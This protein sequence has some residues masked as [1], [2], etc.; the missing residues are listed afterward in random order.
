MRNCNSFTKRQ[1]N[2][3]K[4]LNMRIAKIN[5]P[6][7]EIITHESYKWTIEQTKQFGKIPKIKFY[8]HSCQV[9]AEIVRESGIIDRNR[10][11][12]LSKIRQKYGIKESR[13]SNARLFEAELNNIMLK[14]K[15]AVY[16]VGYINN[17][18]TAKDSSIAEPLVLLQKIVMEEQAQS[19]GDNKTL[20][21]EKTAD[22]S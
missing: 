4:A 2:L 21:H 20:K 18:F 14:V 22:T 15:K 9:K 6:D 11:H 13:Y 8:P 17:L 10:N 5:D 16:T 1:I 12:E 3:I 19:F 7:P